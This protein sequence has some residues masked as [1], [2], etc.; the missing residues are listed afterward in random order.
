M[1][2]EKW[3]KKLHAV[4]ENTAKK[5]GNQVQIAKLSIDKTTL[6][7]EMTDVFT[8]LGKYC[9]LNYEN[10][11]AALLGIKEYKNDIENLKLKIAELDKEIEEVKTSGHEDND[12]SVSYEEKTDDSQIAFTP[13]THDEDDDEIEN[14]NSTQDEE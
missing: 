10:E 7:K 14:N 8:A 3:G 12:F 1:D 9:Y 5:A 6:Q 2:L 4:A 13:E 11:N